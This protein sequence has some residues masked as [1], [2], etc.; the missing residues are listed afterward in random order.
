[1]KRNIELRKV[2]LENRDDTGRFLVISNRTGR[3]YFVEPIGP[4]MPANWGSYNPSTGNIENKKGFDKHR[5]SVSEK[6]SLITKENGF[7]EIT[8]SG[9]GGSPFSVIEELDSK[10]PDLNLS[11]EMS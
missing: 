4:D 7:S 6:E 3:V 2:F 11:P 5:G 8:Y 9:I 10:Y 1:M